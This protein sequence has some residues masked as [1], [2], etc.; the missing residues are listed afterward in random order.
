[1]LNEATGQQ[2]DQH[3]C[4]VARPASGDSVNGLG[5]GW[6]IR[7]LKIKKNGTSLDPIR[8]SVVGSGVDDTVLYV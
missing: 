1:M 6:A 7:W 5:S 8:S 4:P 2:A 3:V